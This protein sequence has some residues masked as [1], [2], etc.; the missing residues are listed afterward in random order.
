MTD[1]ADFKSR[2]DDGR[3]V[4]LDGEVMYVE[5]LRDMPEASNQTVRLDYNA[6]VHCRQGRIELE[7]GSDD[8]KRVTAHG[9][10]LILLPANKLL[11]PM[12]VSTD[13]RASILLVSD[14]VLREVLGPHIDLWNRAMF[15][16][17]IY[18]IDGG[19]WIRCASN[20]AEILLGAGG[21]KK[22]LVLYREILLS[23][24]RTLFLMVCELLTRQL[25]T[26]DTLPDNAATS[27]G[28]RGIFDRFLSLIAHEPT[29]RQQVSYYASRLNITSK[30]LSAVCKKVSGKSPSRW[31]T[32]TVM[33]DICHMLRDTNLSVKEI[34][35]QM[36]FPNSSFFGQYF[37]DEAGMT[38][39]EYRDK[40]RHV[41]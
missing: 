19:S 12:M 24:L 30:Y 15:L 14:K 37:K 21:T 5:D 32:E 7:V 39:L 17:E 27:H 28:E 3:L 38:P 8:S 18:V 34:S 40:T 16:G 41:L 35:N 20:Y 4:N 10:Q 29:K 11:Q 9:G 6:V 22:P 13:L 25:E 26:A 31:I 36:G 1:N 23:F 33:E 2:H